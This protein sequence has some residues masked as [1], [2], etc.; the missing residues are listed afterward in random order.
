M[1]PAYYD[2]ANYLASKGFGVVGGAIF[3]GE[4]GSSGDSDI[5]AQILVKDGISAP[6]TI[7]DQAEDLTVQILVRGEKRESQ[8]TLHTRAMAIYN[9][10][11][12]YY[13]LINMG[14]TCYTDFE[15][16]NF[17]YIGRDDQER[18]LYTMNFQTYRNPI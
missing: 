12:S 2:V 10:F 14:G 15:P 11:V 9:H 3:G 5:D 16:E 1:N 4:F 13:G 18:P 17:A 8:L 7:K 6:F